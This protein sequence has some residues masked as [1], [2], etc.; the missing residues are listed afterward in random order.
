MKDYLNPFTGI[1]SVIKPF[2]DIVQETAE[3]LV[4]FF[5]VYRNWI[6][7][8]DYIYRFPLEYYE[9]EINQMVEDGKGNI[10]MERFIQH[11]SEKA[12]RNR[13]YLI[14]APFMSFVFCAALAIII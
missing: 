11:S 8:N 12:K 7:T 2:T 3:F 14:F 4:S 5:K 1:K 10:E 13:N 6:A 9:A